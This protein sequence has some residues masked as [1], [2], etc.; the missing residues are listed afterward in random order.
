VDGGQLLQLFVSLFVLPFVLLPAVGGGAVMAGYRLAKIPNITF[1]R[2]WKTYLASCCYAFLALIPLRLV[3]RPEEINDS[4]RQ[5]IHLSV[6]L[7]IQLLVV[8]LLLRSFSRK[9][10]SVT[11]LA[12]LLTNLV[13]WILLNDF[14]KG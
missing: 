7:G 8:P 13:A 9:A 14:Q 1:W 4:T 11:F 10:L 2:C 3:L 6:F 5:A 12:V